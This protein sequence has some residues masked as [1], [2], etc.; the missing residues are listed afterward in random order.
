MLRRGHLLEEIRHQFIKKTVAG[1]T[2]DLE[3]NIKSRH[4]RKRNWDQA[5]STIVTCKRNR[6]KRNVILIREKK[7]VNVIEL[8][9][10]K[11]SNR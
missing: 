1:K 8:G 3:R 5:Q 9:R 11:T 4:I 7:Y 10:K 6:F 2:A